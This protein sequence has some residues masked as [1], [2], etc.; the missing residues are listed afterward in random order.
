MS[1]AQKVIKYLA[2]AFAISLIVS[3]FIGIYQAIGT[4]YGVLTNSTGEDRPNVNNYPNLSNILIVDI[5]A[6]QLKIEEG[7]Y[8]KVE[9]NNKYI[10][11]FQENNKLF[12]K[13]KSHGI[14]KTKGNEEVIIYV[15][16]DMIFNKVYIS[17]G[18]GKINIENITAYD[19]ELELGAGKINIERITTYNSTDIQ[20]GAG[21]VTINNAKL[22]NLDLDVGVGKFTLNASITGNSKIDAGVGQLNINLLDSKDNY[23]IYTE[24]GIG[25]AKID[26][27]PVK[28]ES[29]Y[30]IGNSKIDIEGGIGSI[31]ITFK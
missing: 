9:S 7:E 12:V 27:Y 11:S 22:N 23:S 26:G 31:N 3:I 6:S 19:L 18:A 24:T 13:E 16:K 4:T 5:G 28:D 21:E 8:L 15:P 1:S 25:S 30:G 20:G 29:I 10:T 14:F 2:I 17:N